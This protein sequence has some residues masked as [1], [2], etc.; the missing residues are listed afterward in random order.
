MQKLY[1]ACFAAGKRAAESEPTFRSV[2]LDDEPSW[3]E[4][5][6]ECAA[7]PGQTA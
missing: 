5:A 3:Y 2:N 4:I 1:D 6:L 7:N